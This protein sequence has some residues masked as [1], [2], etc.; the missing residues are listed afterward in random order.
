MTFKDDNPLDCVVKKMDKL[1]FFSEIKDDNPLD[2]LVKKLRIE[3][4]PQ[5][6][7]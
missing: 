7:C 3:F 6:V 1:V 4:L 2:C 5:K